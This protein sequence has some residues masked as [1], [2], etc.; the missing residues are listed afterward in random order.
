[1]SGQGTALAL[2][3]HQAGV[4]VRIYESRAPE[5]PELTS[6]VVL[7][8][9]GLR[10]LDA[11]GVFSRIAPRC[12]KA[13]YRT[14]KNDRDETTRKTLIANE[15]LYGYKNHRI[16]RRLLLAEMKLMLA[17]RG[18]GVE[19][20]SRFNGIVEEREDRV[21]FRVN[22]REE[23]GGMLVGADGIFSSVRR[24]VAPGIVPEYTGVLGVLAHIRR[25]TVKWPYP[26]YE[27]ACTIQGKP[28]AFITMPEDPD[29]S[30]IMVA[31]QV[32]HP[33]QSRA[34]WDAMSAD[35]D[36]M[37][38]YFAAG[39][40]QWH[41]T[42]KRIIDQVCASKDTLY[43]WPFLRMPP[44]ER[45]FSR[46][47]RVILVGDAAHAIPPSSGQGVN[48]ALEDVYGLTVVLKR[49]IDLL[50]ALGRWQAMRQKR[51]DAVFDWATNK[52]NVQRLPEAERQK[53]I[54]NGKVK[55]PKASNDFDDMRWLYDLNL[56][57]VVE[58]LT[59]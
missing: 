28:G 13:E 17:E 26:D 43:L 23:S 12:W 40:D 19:Y 3:L 10:V 16:W 56:E 29:A 52:T 50:V 46:A 2:S 7:T 15:A 27:P 57:Q 33:D 38:S 54:A 31:M 1:M 24:Y 58:N 59:T 35:K 4:S 39:Y 48:Q 11:L 14:F 42:A 21:V 53:L 55:D 5:A 8:P 36:K 18:V 25:D 47:G 20:D 44:I 41:D 6:G 49:N 45:W 37:A 9:N 34:E 32:R 22:D 51:I 30:E